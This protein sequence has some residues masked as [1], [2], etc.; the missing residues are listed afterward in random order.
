MA[1]FH[2]YSRGNQTGSGSIPA[3]TN[4][5]E[6]R[7]SDQLRRAAGCHA[8]FL[9][10]DGMYCI[11][12]GD[13]LPTS[14]PLYSAVRQTSLTPRQTSRGGTIRN[15]SGQA[16]QEPTIVQSSALPCPVVPVVWY[17]S[18]SN[19]PLRVHN[20]VEELYSKPPPIKSKIQLSAVITHH[21]TIAIYRIS[22]KLINP[23][24]H[25]NH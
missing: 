24:Q 18:C 25:I 13:D 2:R 16:D 17:E 22:P 21:P 12:D 14:P 11:P 3:M 23:P 15:T 5:T 7:Q 8:C 6:Q 9:P 19:P 4:L 1:R 20:Q 10:V